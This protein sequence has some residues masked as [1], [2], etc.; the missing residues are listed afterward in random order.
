[1]HSAFLNLLQEIGTGS[2]GINANP[3]KLQAGK[4]LFG[5]T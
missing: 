3:F 5:S 4:K 1:M 2:I